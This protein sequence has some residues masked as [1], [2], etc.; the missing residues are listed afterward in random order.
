MLGEAVGRRSGD[1]VDSGGT[2]KRTYFGHL[3][4]QTPKRISWRERI[5]S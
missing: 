5:C 2:T 4:L 3:Q 1:D